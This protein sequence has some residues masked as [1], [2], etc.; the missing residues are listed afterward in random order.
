MKS[1]KLQS[2][3][4]L[5]LAGLLG[6]GIAMSRAYGQS[7]S[8]GASGPVEH[9]PQIVCDEPTHNFGERDENETV[10]HTFVIR[11][12]GDLTLEIHNVR[13]SC[14]CTVANISTKQVEP[15]GETHVTA[16]LSLKGRRGQQHKAIT[17]ES[18]DPKTPQMQ[19]ALQGTSA[20]KLSVQPAQLFFGQIDESAES[21]AATEIASLTED[22]FQITKVESSSP[23]FDGQVEVLED[24]R[25]YRLVVSTRGAVPKGGARGSIR[26]STDSPT[27]PI[28]D[29]PVSA[30]V[31]DEL[32]VAPDQIILVEREGEGVTRFVVVRPGRT[33]EFAVQSVETPDPAI[34]VEVVG[35]GQQGYQIRLDNVVATRELDGKKLKIITNVQG[36]SEIEIP[37]RI[38]P[39]GAQ[40]G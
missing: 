2:R 35:M 15:G 21:T 14:G 22:R 23:N 10:E 31:L 40:A 36:M 26:V 1:G 18:N 9:R 32:T 4:I 19:L 37:F 11:N 28:I 16:R 3:R 12:A 5:L 39:Q 30:T 6:L 34:R 29:I 13:T 27:Y 7:E 25:K 24:G 33:K 8:E 38:I 20:V 17:V